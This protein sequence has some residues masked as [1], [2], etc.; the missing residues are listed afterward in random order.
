MSIKT[1]RILYPLI[2]LMIMLSKEYEILYYFPVMLISLEYLNHKKQYTE[3]YNYKLLN[4]VFIGYVLFI[5]IDRGR[6]SKFYDVIEIMIN[7]VEHLLFGFII[8]M[9]AAVYLSIF[10]ERWQL[11]KNELLTIA[12][13]FNIL[14]FLNEFFQNWYKHQAQ[15]KLNGDSQKDIL[16]NIIGSSIFVILYLKVNKRIQ[17]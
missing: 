15:W 14:G 11:S 13:I 17:A 2:L 7:S 4:A 6:P 5:C 16:M 10:K 9:K 1:V 3:H 12:L 8:C